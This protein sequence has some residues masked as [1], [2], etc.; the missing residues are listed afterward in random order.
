[1]TCTRCGHKQCYICSVDIIGYEHFNDP[2]R[3]G[4]VGNCE[5]FDNHEVRHE[6]EI[7]AAAA[8]ARA[9]ILAKNPDLTP[10]ALEIKLSEK[11]K[12]ADAARIKAAE[13]APGVVAARA[14]AAGRARI[15]HPPPRHPP[16]P[17]RLPPQ[18]NILLQ[19]HRLLVDAERQNRAFDAVQ[20]AVQQAAQQAVNF[21]NPL[22]PR[23]RVNPPVGAAPQRPQ[24]VYPPLYGYPGAYPLPEPLEPRVGV[25]PYIPAAPPPPPP[26]PPALP[27]RNHNPLVGPEERLIALNAHIARLEQQVKTDSENMRIFASHPNLSTICKP[28]LLQSIEELARRKSQADQE[29]QRIQRRNNRAQYEADK[30]AARAVEDAKLAERRNNA[31]YE[32][33]KARIRSAEDVKREERKNRRL[34]EREQQAA[35]NRHI[36]EVLMENVQRNLQEHRNG[37]VRDRR[38]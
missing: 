21:W 17:P 18:E 12:A 1:M 13:R 31:Q 28:K 24:P 32:A 8:A 5:L 11:V 36:P 20:Q 26:P 37:T 10:E 29:I 33:E 38:S 2:N 3:G 22:Q 6:N 27:P 19:A 9:K 30:A 7:A 23:P 25:R 35:N 16:P 4:K 14:V 15:H 34:E